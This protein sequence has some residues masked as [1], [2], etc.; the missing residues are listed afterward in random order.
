MTYFPLTF[1]FWWYTFTEYYYWYKMNTKYLR[2]HILHLKS[3]CICKIPGR[4]RKFRKFQEIRKF[5]VFFSEYDFFW[6][7]SS[8]NISISIFCQF[9]PTGTIFR[10]GDIS[11]P[12]T[13]AIIFWPWVH[14]VIRG[15]TPDGGRWKF[16]A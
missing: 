10:W 12:P 16:L 9:G 1:H 14:K 4:I 11:S 5:Q 6:K 3:L 13:H 15:V 2:K 7:I 8:R